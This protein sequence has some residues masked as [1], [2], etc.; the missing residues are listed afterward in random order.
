VVLKT[1]CLKQTVGGGCLLP[2]AGNAAP[3]TPS[4]AQPSGSKLPR[5]RGT[6][7]FASHMARNDKGHPKVAFVW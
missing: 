7:S 5:H 1:G 3:K 4:A 2:V 6:A